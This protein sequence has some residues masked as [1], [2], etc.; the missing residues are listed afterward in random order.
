MVHRGVLTG[1]AGVANRADELTVPAEAVPAR[2][3][4]MEEK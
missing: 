3:A 1:V 2:L 4:A